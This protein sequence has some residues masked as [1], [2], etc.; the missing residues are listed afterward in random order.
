MGPGIVPRGGGKEGLEGRDG[1]A[2]TRGTILNYVICI[3]RCRGTPIQQPMK[4]T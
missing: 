4:V 1:E 2:G 3:G